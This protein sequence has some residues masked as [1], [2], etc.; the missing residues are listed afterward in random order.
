MVC[1]IARGLGPE[2]LDEIKGLEDETGLT[3]VAFACRSLDPA[4][5]ERLKALQAEMG[6]VLTVEPARPSEGQL[7]RIRAL[8]SALGVSLV[9]VRLEDAGATR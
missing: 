8:E 9:A 3:V 6:P 1:E 5:E 7:A 2:Q 4:R